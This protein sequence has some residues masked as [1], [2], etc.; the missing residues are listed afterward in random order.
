MLVSIIIP[1]YKKKEYINKTVDSILSQTYKKF[2]IIIINDELTKDS[3]DL[4]FE[5]KK[6]R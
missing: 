1:Y 2:E 6:K 5:L 3:F 4:L